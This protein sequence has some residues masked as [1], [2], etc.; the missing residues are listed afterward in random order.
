MFLIALLRVT[1]SNQARHSSAVRPNL[2]KAL[3]KSPM[4][5]SLHFALG[6]NYN[7]PTRLSPGSDE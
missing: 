3:V 6:K 1:I 5:T 2:G 7:F 4:K